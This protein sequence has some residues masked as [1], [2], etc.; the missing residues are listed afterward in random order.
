MIEKKYFLRFSV[1]LAIIM[2]CALSYFAYILPETASSMTK[3]QQKTFKIDP[4]RYRAM[5]V[6]DLNPKGTERG[7][8]ISSLERGIYFDHDG[9]GF[10]EKTAWLSWY[11]KTGLLVRVKDGD[12]NI[13][14]GLKLFGNNTLLSTG[15]KAKDGFEALADLDANKDGVID[16]QDPAFSELYLWIDNE[17]GGISSEDEL[18][19]LKEKQISSISVRPRKIKHVSVDKNVITLESFYTR[20]DGSKGSLRNIWVRID[21][22]KAK[23]ITADMSKDLNDDI[24]TLKR[25]GNVRTLRDA[26]SIDKTK[27]IEQLYYRF[28][29][30]TDPKKRSL[31]LTDLIYAWVGVIDIDPASRS[32]AELGG[33]VIGDA[34]KLATI[35]AFMGE[36]YL[37]TMPDGRRDPNPHQ[38]AAPLLLRAFETLKIH[39]N[40]Q[41][42]NA[43]HF[44]DLI[45]KVDVR[46][47]APE[48]VSADISRMRN[49]LEKIYQEQGIQS[50]GYFME[51]IKAIKGANEKLVLKPLE[52][53]EASSPTPFEK[54]WMALDLSGTIEN[55]TL[56]ADETGSIL[57]GFYGDDTLISGEGNDYLSGG[58]GSDTYIFDPNFGHDI[59]DDMPL[60]PLLPDNDVIVFEKGLL[61]EEAVLKRQQNDLI[62][63][64][65]NG[66]DSVHIIG[67]FEPGPLSNRIEDI[68]FGNE[69]MVVWSYEDVLEKLSASKTE[70][71]NGSE[72][73]R[74]PS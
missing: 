14:N 20:I 49:D 41:L 30:E 70:T 16:E 35:E 46:W 65:K 21:P 12:K 11:E 74:P 8:E 44:K 71:I 73:T 3:K 52:I 59:I 72:K 34:R 64:F 10:A 29:E 68:V 1:L 13:N 18:I 50:Y 51:L 17:F 24:P 67:Y 32:N 37:G 57:F 19:P 45:T 48:K 61:P 56:S 25:F 22:S 26:A 66:K 54:A 60:D 23:E 31:I 69:Q 36:K 42:M 63:S 43:T 33:N 4:Q 9:N 55:D 53:K 7:E 5:L 47:E 15:E 62:I 27:R 2:A 58:N 28:A 6:V 39:I 40:S 38:Y